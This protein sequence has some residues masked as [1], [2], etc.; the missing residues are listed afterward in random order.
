M[1]LSPDDDI[2]ENIDDRQFGIIFHDAMHE[3]YK[4]VVGKEM[5]ADEIA[6]LASELSGS[7]IDYAFARHI[8]PKKE[9]MQKLALEGKINVKNNLNG[10]NKLVY[11]V[12][13]HYVKSQLEYD[14]S[15]AK[16]KPITFVALEEKYS[17][18][19]PIELNGRKIKVNLGGIIDRIDKIGDEIRIIDYKTG[20]NKV[21][22]DTIDDVFDAAKISDFKG[23]LQTLIYCL[24]FSH[25][26]ADEHITPH[27][28]M[29]RELDHNPDFRIRSK[30]DEF[31]EGSYRRVEDKVKAFV[32]SVLTDIFDA[33]K[34]FVQTDNEDNCKHCNFFYLCNKQ[35]G[36]DEY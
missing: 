6:K 33:D 13:E 25:K 31:S 12:I 8:F 29:T 22:C 16:E 27:L 20:S 30:N 1:R 26:R 7:R 9:E 5:G 10:A 17:M 21:E 2:D 14:K 3:I 19:F 18:L 35:A 32:T 23:I 24:I 4:T 28:F 15:V 36:F 34:P 11:S